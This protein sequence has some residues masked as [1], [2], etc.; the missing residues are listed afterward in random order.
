MNKIIKNY[1]YTVSYNIVLMVLPLITIPYKAKILGPE[2]IGIYSYV[3][4]VFTYLVMMGNI[5]INYYGRREIAYIKE[6]KDK[7]SEIFYELLIL[8]T[9]ITILVMVVFFFIFGVRS[10]YFNFYLI[11]SIDIFFTILDVTWF[12]QGVEEFKK[13]SIISIIIKIINVFATFI[14]I[15]TPNDLTNYFIITV[16]CDSLLIVLLF[17]LIPKY[18]GRINRLNIIKHLKPCLII[19]MPQI[20]YH[21]YGILDKIMLGNLAENISQVAFYEYSDKIIKIV[22]SILSSVITVMAPVLSNEFIKKK[23]QSLNEYMQKTIRFIFLIGIPLTFGLVA[24]SNNLVSV[25]LGN[26]YL[27]MIPI[28]KILAVLI[29]LSGITLVVGEQYLISVKKENK[30]TILIIIG[31]IINIALNLLL[32][33]KYEAVGAAIATI[34]GQM[35]IL[36]LEIPIIKQFVNKSLMKSFTKYLLFSIIMYIVVYGIGLI[37]NSAIILTTQIIVGTLIYMTI[38]FLTKDDFFKRNKEDCS[39]NTQS[40]KE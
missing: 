17:T 23:S 31:I 11:M 37:N 8:K 5:G 6:N 2:N 36:I 27:E 20:Y 26:S 14:F 25:V 34:L 4:S 21:I 28:I 13:I 29:I 33:P 1:L 9:V 3:F 12:L 38:L 22:L 40:S 19:F 15:R 39:V 30:Y 10:E 24:I 32:I 35:V 7:R 18:V 16:V